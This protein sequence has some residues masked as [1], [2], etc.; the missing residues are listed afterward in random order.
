MVISSSEPGPSANGPHADTH[1]GTLWS[2]PSSEAP[3]QPPSTR[4]HA[5]PGGK[6]AAWGPPVPTLLNTQVCTPRR[7]LCLAPGGAA[8]RR[9]PP[10]GNLPP[11]SP[12]RPDHLP[13]D[14]TAQA[15]WAVP[16]P[17][18]PGMHGHLGHAPV[19]RSDPVAP[20]AP[21]TKAVIPLDR[22]GACALPTRGWHFHFNSWVLSQGVKTLWPCYGLKVLS[23]H[24]SVVSNSLQP[25]GLYPARLLCPWGSPGKNTG[26][27]CHF[28]LQGTFLTQ[29]SKL[30]FLSLL[31]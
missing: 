29:G 8:P 7:P 1:P 2:Y 24:H 28:L 18:S 26:V 20:A 21:W 23:V 5:G 22:N 9:P 10:T 17:V 4:R 27:G 15:G 16:S 19:G 25:R 11:V 31:L 12:R 30:R 14:L 13:S 3:S 6:Q